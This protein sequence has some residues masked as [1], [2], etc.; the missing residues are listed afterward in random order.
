MIPGSN[1]L[2]FF[3]LVFGNAL[4]AQI[5][6][7]ARLKER[8]NLRQVYSEEECAVIIA[9]VVIQS[10]AG[11]D[12]EAALERIQAGRPVI[13]VVLH[14]TF[15]PNYIAPDSKWCVNREG[16]FTVDVLFHED[17]GLL[18]SLHNDMA[19]KRTTD[20]LIS[21]NASPHPE[22]ENGCR[23]YPCWLIALLII[24]CFICVLMV[25][26]VSFFEYFMN[27]YFISFIFLLV[28][29]FFLRSKGER[30]D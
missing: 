14:H 6:F 12:I 4:G 2:P 11:T 9:F 20:H 10:R 19:L 24:L 8:L 27:I 13:L 30:Q 7:L 16:V 17:E 5:N 1:A 23:K 22:P 18:R 26:P 25:I 28:L 15:D 3:T 21:L 29:F